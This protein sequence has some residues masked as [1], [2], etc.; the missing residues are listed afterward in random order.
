MALVQHWNITV[1]PYESPPR[2]G[3]HSIHVGNRQQ[4]RCR[5][6]L[7]VAWEDW[8]CQWPEIHCRWSAMSLTSQPFRSPK[9]TH[10]ADLLHLFR[11]LQMG[12]IKV[13]TGKE[14]MSVGQKNI[15]LRVFHLQL[16]SWKVSV[17][18][19]APCIFPP[20]QK[21]SVWHNDN[22]EGIPDCSTSSDQSGGKLTPGWGQAAQK[23]AKLAGPG[24]ESVWWPNPCHFLYFKFLHSLEAQSSSLYL[25]WTNLILTWIM[26]QNQI[27]THR[28]G[29]RKTGGWQS[30][31]FI[32][33]VQG[34]GLAFQIVHPEVIQHLKGEQC[35]NFLVSGR[36]EAEVQIL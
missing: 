3:V 15:I 14:A 26:N 31:Q 22:I 1:L 17:Q 8:P 36:P 16:F 4:P 9:D 19:I 7:N 20:V 33:I 28:N 13:F 21:K 34:R 23:R 35:F 6:E 12:L 24:S 2:N 18:N 29:M 11:H 30:S 5:C 10:F 27:N 25:S 32:V